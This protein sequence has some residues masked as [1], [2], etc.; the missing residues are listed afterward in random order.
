[1]AGLGK[2]LFRPDLRFKRQATVGSDWG[3]GGKERE[4]EK[5]GLGEGLLRVLE[6]KRLTVLVRL[7]PHC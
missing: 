2:I 1:M 6:D 7:S 3:A 4:G 5:D